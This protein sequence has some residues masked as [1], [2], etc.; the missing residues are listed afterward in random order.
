[1]NVELRKSCILGWRGLLLHS[2]SERTL[3]PLSAFYVL[4]V[5]LLSVAWHAV[6]IL[7]AL[8]QLAT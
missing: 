8:R 1:M 7:A 6:A 2:Y 5:A 3:D 4:F